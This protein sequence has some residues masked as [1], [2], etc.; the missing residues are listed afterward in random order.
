MI[1]AMVLVVNYTETGYNQFSRL[2]SSIM[3]LAPAPKIT[4]AQS[5]GQLFGSIPRFVLSPY[6]W[7]ASPEKDPLYGLYPGMWY[8]YLVVYPLAAAG[9]FWSIKSDFRIAVIPVLAFWCSAFILIM[10]VY[11]GNASRQRYY[12]EYIV[13]I[14]AGIGCVQ[15]NRMLSALILVLEFIFAA[16]Q[17]IILKG[18]FH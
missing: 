10:A 7:V 6:A 2:W 14:F 12:L 18:H 3:F 8:L 16:G 15:P 5:V 4:T 13:M 9:F 11:A 17:L 1:V